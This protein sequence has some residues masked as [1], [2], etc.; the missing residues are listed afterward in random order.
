MNYHWLRKPAEKDPY[1]PEVSCQMEGKNLLLVHPGKAGRI[2]VLEK[3]RQMGVNIILYHDKKSWASGSVCVQHEI[4]GPYLDKSVA[5]STVQTWM[6]DTKTKIDAVWTYDDFALEI[7]AYMS[8]HLETT[9]PS[10]MPYEAIQIYTNKSLFREKS[11][12]AK[13]P[14]PDNVF[15]PVGILNDFKEVSSR[16]SALTFPFVMKPCR[17]AGSILLRRV[18]N[19]A[20]IKAMVELYLRESGSVFK[21]LNQ[22]GILAEEIITGVEVDV[23]C[24]IYDSKVIFA[25]VSD[26]HP[27]PPDSAAFCLEYGGNCPSI[28]PNHIKQSFLDLLQAVVR[29]PDTPIG[30]FFHF[31]SIYCEKR[32][33]AV[34]VELNCRPGGAETNINIPTAWGLYAPE[35]ALKVLFRTID[36]DS[37]PDCMV[38]PP[39]HQLTSINIHPEVSGR[40]RLIE[41]TANQ[42]PEK[43]GYVGH[44]FYF[45]VSDVIRFPPVGYSYLG[46]MV[47]KGR[48]IDEARSRLNACM[49][50]VYFEFEDPEKEQALLEESKAK[51]EPT[52]ITMQ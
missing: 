15:L 32:Q 47:C 28:L 42:L 4:F 12:E 37:Y 22:P 41:Q 38:D 14:T 18:N 2:V 20:E 33:T 35:E 50:C 43:E 17:G 44:A 5:L 46:W 9:C 26:N 45:K 29:L 51:Q 39:I 6:A 19:E 10:I 7:C 31:E 52:V 11:Q 40:Q 34:P 8:E 24:L 3:F 48:D 1:E 23:D 16:L 30:G 27:A 25:C 36:P 13:I 49:E 21:Q